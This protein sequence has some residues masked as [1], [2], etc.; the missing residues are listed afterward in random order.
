MR[1]NPF[2]YF[3]LP[4]H[5][6]VACWRRFSFW[7]WSISADLLDGQGGKGNSASLAVL[8]LTRRQLD[9]I[10]LPLLHYPNH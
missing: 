9:R 4:P 2:V 5:G 6:L 1:Y 10:L 7:F 8:L 3:I